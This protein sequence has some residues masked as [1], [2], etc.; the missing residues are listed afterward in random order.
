MPDLTLLRSLLVQAVSDN[1]VLKDNGAFHHGATGVVVSGGVDSSTVCAIARDLVGD[2]PTFT[3]YYDTEGFDERPYA[4]L[5]AGANHHEIPITPQDFIDNFDAMVPKLRP[6][7]QGM[8]TFGQYMVGKYISENTDVKVVLSGEGADELFGGY[9]RLIAV[10]K[11][12]GFAVDDVRLPD[13]YENY[14]IPVGYP[15]NTYDALE[16]DWQRLPDLLAVDDQCMAAHGLE[17]RAPFTEEPVITFAH[18]LYA[19]DRVAKT[20]LKD[21]MRGIVPD[22]ILDRTDK[23]GFPIPL[24]RWAQNEL[25]DFVGDRIGYIP[26]PEKPWDRGFWYDLLE[27]GRQ[28]VAA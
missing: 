5:V 23:Q 13:G 11:Q 2:L 20:V 21:A 24:N 27:H 25:R 17:A 28:S 19:E 16:Y 9:A 3:G 7:Y 22:A 18:G 6:P 1:I 26:N 10:A 14:R 8:G 4:R 15:R 12:C